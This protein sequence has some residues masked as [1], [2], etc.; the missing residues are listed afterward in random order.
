MAGEIAG[1][2]LRVL[3]TAQDG[4][5][6]HAGCS[7]TRCER[8]LADP[9]FARRVSSLAIVAPRTDGHSAV[10]LIDASPDVREQLVALRDVREA[11]PAAVRGRVDRAPVD[12]VLLT[13]AH[14]GH[15]LG[16]AFFGFEAISTTRLPVWSTPRMA[17]YLR[18]NGPW[19]QLVS[20][21]NLLLNE[22]EP[23]A[24]FAL[25]GGVRVTVEPVPH[26]DEYADTVG[27]RL[28]G[29]HRTVFYVPD[30]D[31]WTA[32]Q[33]SLLDR[34]AGVDLALLDGTFYSLDEL[35]GRDLS[36]IPHPLIT[37]TMELLER[38]VAAGEL[39][40]Y[41]THLNHSNPALEPESEARREIEERG[42][43]VLEDGQEIGL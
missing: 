24:S 12:G 26:R 28:K 10:Y 41:F 23:G 25:E 4:G 5:L 17:A 19:S 20:R 16:L 9:G 30:T 22:I 42:F 14:I 29:P 40:V 32:W 31:A 33:P 27:F 3:G 6:P 35:P 21:E 34:L 15:Y 2:F 37:H 13:H 38:R 18:A 39:T 7:C 8:A 1:P 36:E 11:R 43:R